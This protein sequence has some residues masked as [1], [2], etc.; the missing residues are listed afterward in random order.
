MVYR[1]IMKSYKKELR[2][3]NKV[4]EKKIKNCSIMSVRMFEHRL[5]NHTASGW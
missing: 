4:R 5:C 2:E 3:K 1:A